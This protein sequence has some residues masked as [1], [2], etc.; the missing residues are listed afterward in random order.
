MGSFKG[1][2][3]TEDSYHESHVGALEVLILG[4]EVHVLL[5]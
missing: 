1:H 2:I 5:A 4:I 3:Q